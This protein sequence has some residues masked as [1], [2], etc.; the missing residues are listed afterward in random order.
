MAGGIG[1]LPSSGP[2]G[3]LD[4]RRMPGR[5][6]VAERVRSPRVRGRAIRELPADRT[7]P[8]AAR[9][10]RRRR[11]DGRGA[12]R[13]ALGQRR[14]AAARR[15]TSRRTRWPRT[16]AWPGSR[17]RPSSS[18]RRSPASARPRPPSWSPRSSSGRRLLAD[19]PTGR[20]SIRGPRDV[21]D[22]LILQMGRLE[23]EELRV[24][25]LDTKNH[26]LRVATVYQGNVSRRRWSASASC[27]ATPSGS[28]PRA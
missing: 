21:A 3:R 19:W 13:A 2:R 8:R 17:G 22:R 10:A 11:A 16:T 12:D 24:V 6:A 25:I 5:S 27:S 23:R 28:T 18:S 7:A 15:S 14:R 26:V 1:G 9:P 4:R 20:W